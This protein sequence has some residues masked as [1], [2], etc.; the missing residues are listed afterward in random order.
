M[1]R[2]I[3]DRGTGIG[4]TLLPRIFF[5]RSLSLAAL[6]LLNPIPLC[7]HFTMTITERPWWRSVAIY[8]VY[9]ASFSDSNNDGIGDLRGIIHRLDYIA[10]IGVD[11]IWIC[12]MYDR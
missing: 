2:H 10:S 11:T 3:N 6:L 8:Q 4:E 7:S 1:S 12:P 9:P 5:L